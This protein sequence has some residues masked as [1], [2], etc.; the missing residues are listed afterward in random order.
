MNILFLGNSQILTAIRHL[1]KLLN[2]LPEKDLYIQDIY[3]PGAKIP[4]LVNNFKKSMS[5]E[6]ITTKSHVGNRIWTYSYGNDKWDEVI[7]PDIS[8]QDVLKNTQWDFIIT[9]GHTGKIGILNYHSCIKKYITF[10]KE[11]RKCS[12]ARIYWLGGLTPNR[13]YCNTQLYDVC[14]GGSRMGMVNY[15]KM[16][17]EKICNT[18]HLEYIPLRQAYEVLA[19]QFPGYNHLIIDNVHPDKGIGEYFCTAYLYN[20]LFKSLYDVDLSELKFSYN[21]SKYMYKD[22][23]IQCI[24][25]NEEIKKIAD[26]IADF[27]YI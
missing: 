19:E 6:F 11:I 14:S 23:N 9:C 20:F 17:D 4:T 7:S 8:I 21:A 27:C 1:P 13:E 26:D 3:A 5:T 18:F 10:F 16:I 12:N 15:L 22:S 25:V 2:Q 24:S